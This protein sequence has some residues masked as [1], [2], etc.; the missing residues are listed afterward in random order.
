[1]IYSLQIEVTQPDQQE[2]VSTTTSG[3]LISVA[4][5]IAVAANIEGGKRASQRVAISSRPLANALGIGPSEVETFR[6]EF[7]CA[8]GPARFNWSSATP[9]PA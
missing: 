1:M 9:I 4:A 3:R 2:Q 6:T 8:W 7:L 5:I